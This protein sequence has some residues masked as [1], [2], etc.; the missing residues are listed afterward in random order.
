MCRRGYLNRTGF[1]S[2]CALH[3]HAM[4]QQFALGGVST[5]QSLSLTT[6][7]SQRMTPPLITASSHV[8]RLPMIRKR[9]KKGFI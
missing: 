3:G 5:V 7:N 1:C 2:T 4:V 9:G 6:T 8:L